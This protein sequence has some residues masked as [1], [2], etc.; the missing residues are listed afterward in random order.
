MDCP[1]CSSK[2]YITTQ[3]KEDFV[4]LYEICVFCGYHKGYV[5][6]LDKDT[7][8]IDWSGIDH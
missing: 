2:L 7:G 3:S 5:D 1:E 4:N 8:P 6:Y